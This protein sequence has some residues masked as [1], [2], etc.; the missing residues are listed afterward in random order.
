[1]SFEKQERYVV[2]KLKDLNSEQHQLL[3]ATLQANQIPTRQCVVVEPGWGTLYE[4][5]WAAIKKHA[6][7]GHE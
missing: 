6:E 4:E 1:M 5:T 7:A 3:R 2:V